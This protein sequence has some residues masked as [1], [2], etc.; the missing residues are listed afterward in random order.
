VILAARV[1]VGMKSGGRLL[2]AWAL[3]LVI[4]IFAGWR[5]GGLF[6][7]Y[8]TARNNSWRFLLGKTG[9]KTLTVVG[10]NPSTATDTQPDM[11]IRKIKR[12]VGDNGYDGFVVVN[13]YPVRSTIIEDLPVER[14]D[15]A[16]HQ[17]L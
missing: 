14:D 1:L 10:L 2:V 7:I 12:I 6:D 16:H 5:D 3:D 17:N 13:L 15:E 11:A 8:K 4:D 9:Q